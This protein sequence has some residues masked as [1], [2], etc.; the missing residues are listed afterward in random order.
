M[1]RSPGESTLSPFRDGET[2]ENLRPPTPKALPMGALV[3]GVSGLIMILV[4][5]WLVVRVPVPPLDA[6]TIARLSAAGRLDQALAEVEAHLERA[7]NDPFAR[8]MAAEL[9][10]DQPVS[11][12]DVALKHLRMFRSDH[13]KLRARAAVAEGKARYQQ[14][15]YRSAE[16]RWREALELDAEVP[17]ATWALLDLYYLQGRGAEARELALRQHTIEPD[18]R[19]RVRLLIEL[20]RQDAEPADPASIV[21]RFEATVQGRPSDFHSTLALGLALIRVSRVVEGLSLLSGTTAQFPDQIQAWEALLDGLDAAGDLE[22]L[23]DTWEAVP[24]EIRADGQLSRQE[25]MVAQARGDWHTAAAAFRKAWTARPD[26]QVAAY[27]LARSLHAL[28]LR[29]QAADCD[30]WLES[31]QAAREEVREL[32]RQIDTMPLPVLRA[33]ADLVRQIALNRERLGRLDEA[34]AWRR[35]LRSQSTGQSASDREGNPSESPLV[36]LPTSGS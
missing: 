5:V 33:S 28:G 7:P 26:D 30:R 9:A 12:P 21:A 35:W 18:A 13:P 1:T 29:D 25:G 24:P 2:P 15:E 4:A 19:D 20:L 16:A 27:R 3:A 36:R 14:G 31:A 17:E 6:G 32:Y 22:R 10:L 23:V 34:A 8:L 11:R